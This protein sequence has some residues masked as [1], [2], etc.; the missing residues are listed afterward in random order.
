MDFKHAKRNRRLD[1]WVVVTLLLSMS[2]G[3]NFLISKIDIQV[4]LSPDKKYSLS[5]ESLALLN[6]MEQPVDLVITIKEN[7]AMPKIIGRLLHDLNLLM[8]AFESSQTPFPIRVHRMD[9]FSPV[10]KESVLD[11]SLIHI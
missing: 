8:D 6:K 9:V 7:S 3:L 10:K 5:R 4:D 2:L 11:L 1:R